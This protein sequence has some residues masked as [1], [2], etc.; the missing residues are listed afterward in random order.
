MNGCGKRQN[1]YSILINKRANKA[2]HPTDYSLRSFFTR[3]LL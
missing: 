1:K 2:L 3:R